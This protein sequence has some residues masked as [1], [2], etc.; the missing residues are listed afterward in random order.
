M[1]EPILNV[2]HIHI[3]YSSQ[4]A[5]D[6]V[7]FFI[8]AGEIFGLLGPNG[9]GKTSTLSAIEGLLK[10]Q[11]GKIL[12]AG[13]DIHENPAHAKANMECSCNQLVFSQN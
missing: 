8:E 2:E 6:D 3:Y 5:V 10:P 12:I 7:S 1:N 13:N 9:A 11:S 4:H